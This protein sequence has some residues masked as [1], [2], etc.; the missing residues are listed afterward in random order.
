[1]DDTGPV[2]VREAVD[3]SD[4]RRADALLFKVFGDSWAQARTLLEVGAPKILMLAEID[5]EL[6]G[7]VQGR[8]RGVY[9]PGWAPRAAS[10]DA[11]AVL[12]ACR[13]RGVGEMLAIAII[14]RGAA[15]GAAFALL[16]PG[17]GTG[18][19]RYRRLGWE[20]C[21]AWTQRSVRPASIAFNAV[22]ACQVR[23]VTEAFED[24]ARCYD[25]VAR[26]RP[27]WMTRHASYW[28][29]LLDPDGG[30]ECV[31][32][33]DRQGALVA[34]AVYA[35][36][37]DDR[38]IGLEVTELVGADAPA[39]LAIW[40][41][42]REL[43]G[44]KSVAYPSGPD[45]PFYLLAGEQPRVLSEMHWMARALDVTRAVDGRPFPQGLDASIKLRLH[46]DQEDAN[47]GDWVLVIRGGSGH[48]ARGGRGGCK[49]S[50]GHLTA[51]IFAYA[52][53]SELRNLGLIEADDADVQLLDAAFSG[54][55]S[56]MQEII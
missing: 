38:E 46:D 12:P 33:W 3:E 17:F 18:V 26:H 49:M 56:W 41:A 54:P 53:A 37:E 48:F 10:Y 34:Y 1:M 22:S 40:R 35:R 36:P 52:S 13:D 25:R 16:R 9:L 20:V 42:I 14:K 45:D 31:G 8:L 51:L 30:Q 4:W 27:G 24:L 11:L 44:A 6:V 29:R 32:A 21:G 39:R 2:I 5:G 15:R 28:T 47:C 43:A 19:H 23:P 55:R 50:I 7:C